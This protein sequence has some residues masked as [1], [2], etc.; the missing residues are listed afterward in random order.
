MLCTLYVHTSRERPR[1]T[2]RKTIPPTPLIFAAR[3]PQYRL[4]WKLSSSFK[5][6]IPHP[7]HVQPVWNNNKLVSDFT[8]KS[9]IVYCHRRHHVK[10]QLFCTISEVENNKQILCVLSWPTVQE[11]AQIWYLHLHFWTDQYFLV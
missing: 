11:T 3:F 5:P 2:V 8:T 6:I 7:D 10:T 1:P 9:C 4:I